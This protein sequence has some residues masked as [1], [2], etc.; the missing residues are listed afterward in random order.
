[1]HALHDIWR[2]NGRV[3]P[4]VRR[5]L[6]VGTIVAL[7]A[8]WACR[9]AF[10]PG[11]LDIIKALPNLVAQGLFEQLY[12][13]L[14]TCLE[15]IGITCLLTLPL[16]YLT[17]LPAVRPFVR[18]LSKLRFLGLTGFVVLFTIAFGGGHG[19]KIAL[20][21]FGM[22]VFLITSLYDVVEAIPREAFDHAR[23]LRMGPWTT[24][25]EVVVFGQMAAVLDIIRQNS[26]MGWAMLGIAEG[27]VRFE[28]GLGAMMLTEDKHIRLDSVFAIQLVV[29]F[30]GIALD[31]TWLLVRKTLCPF[32][33]ITLERQ[34]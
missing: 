9:P 29:L 33:D 24:V 4:R 18:I 1:M 11:P 5:A 15:A 13:S 32:A 28:G 25:L 20:L 2:P 30:I 7:F 14:S 17:V 12:S 23:T 10:L 27:L 6:A 22:S 3:S 19:L 31:W 21:V 16:A 34:E 26:A 8:V